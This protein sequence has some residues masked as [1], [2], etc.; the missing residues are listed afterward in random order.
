MRTFHQSPITGTQACPT[1]KQ[2]S[3]PR[4]KVSIHTRPLS[5]IMTGQRVI[6]LTPPLRISGLTQRGTLR[7][8]SPLSCQD[9]R[10]PRHPIPVVRTQ[11]AHAQTSPLKV[12]QVL[13]SSLPTPK[14]IKPSRTLRTLREPNCT[15]PNRPARPSKAIGWPMTNYMKSKTKKSAL[16]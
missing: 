7:R 4:L 11:R 1:Y 14:K 12:G 3:T 6:A 9:A 8:S 5:V 10:V 13:Q 16:I 15:G 2:A